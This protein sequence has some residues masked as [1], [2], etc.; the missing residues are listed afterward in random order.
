MSFVSLLANGEEVLKIAK[1]INESG[2]IL[3]QTDTVFGLVCLGTNEDAIEKIKKIKNRVK[4]SFGFF[5]KNLQIAE[6]Y[7]VFNDIQRQIFN[8]IFPGHFTLILPA[9]NYAK[10]TISNTAL[11][12][13]KKNEQIITTIGLRIPK[14]NFCIKLLSNFDV[15]LLATSANIS[16]QPTAT[17][18]T[19]IPR[20]ILQSVDAIYYDQKHSSKNIAS[21]IVD[22]TDINSTEIIRQGSGDINLIDKIIK[23]YN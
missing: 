15:P 20:E 9:T 4:P 23:K 21:T 3:L 1:I 14:N 5:V 6:K 13:R 17:N 19:D 22:I 7:A 12:T 18:F 8:T 16:G 10:K 11:G 2:V